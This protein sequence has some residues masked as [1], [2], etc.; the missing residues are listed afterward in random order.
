M[1]LKISKKDFFNA[2]SDLQFPK[3]I[4]KEGNR[5]KVL[6]SG[7]SSGKPFSLSHRMKDI[8][9]LIKVEGDRQD[10]MR[11]IEIGKFVFLKESK[12]HFCLMHLIFAIRNALLGRGFCTAKNF[13]REIVKEEIAEHEI[14]RIQKKQEAKNVHQPAIKKNQPLPDRREEEVRRLRENFLAQIE[15]GNPKIPKDAPKEQ[16]K[17][18][19]QTTLAKVGPASLYPRK[20]PVNGG[21]R[22]KSV[23]IEQ[24][25]FFKNF[26]KN[27]IAQIKPLSAAEIERVA[28][29][30]KDPFKIFYFETPREEWLEFIG[31]NLSAE[32][33]VGLQKGIFHESCKGICNYCICI[34]AHPG[35]ADL[36]QSLMEFLNANASLMKIPAL[37]GFTSFGQK[38]KLQT[39]LGQ[40]I[41]AYA[42]HYIRFAL[43]Q[44]PLDKCR[45]LLNH[46]NRLDPIVLQLV[47]LPETSSFNPSE[48]PE[49]E[50]LRFF[51]WSRINISFNQAITPYYHDM[52]CE[53]FKDAV[54][55]NK[56]N[57]KALKEIFS[58]LHKK[59]NQETDPTEF[60]RNFR[61]AAKLFSNAEICDL[62]EQD[63]FK[64]NDEECQ[65]WKLKSIAYALTTEQFASVIKGCRKLN[66][67]SLLFRNLAFAIAIRP[68][69]TLTLPQMLTLFHLDDW[70]AFFRTYH[71]KDETQTFANR[72][73]NFIVKESSESEV[74]N[75]LDQLDA[76]PNILTNAIDL[77]K[78]R[79]NKEISQVAKATL[80][81]W[82]KG[83]QWEQNIS[84]LFSSKE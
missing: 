46:F 56:E 41:M 57:V 14:D 58:F 52:S 67:P 26:Q 55:K 32:Q 9:D 78:K 66:N 82:S 49:K 69:L 68:S 3:A 64:L 5:V 80:L 79:Q 2:Y 76:V 44:E 65:T 17:A 53:R 81:S 31:Q 25:S 30:R 54:Q 33:L 42:E 34:N 27:F 72:Y 43:K 20:N 35:K 74:I 70:S 22:K 50:R 10:K 63:L 18:S 39:K 28:A 24:R 60:S 16:S 19:K 75:C 12:E 11:L 84:S 4:R 47:L 38:E 71:N 21:L 8:S 7:L 61:E 36:F 77:L 51:S 73:L 40:A 13:F 1:I 6:E 37:S 62:A 29:E 23:P 15:G 59:L 48:L 83:K 45:D